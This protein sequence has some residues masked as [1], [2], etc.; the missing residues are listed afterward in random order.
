MK[1]HIS[2]VDLRKLTRLVG[3]LTGRA[4]G[5]EDILT[6]TLEK[7]KPQLVISVH[8]TYYEIIIG[9]ERSELA[10]EFYQ[11]LWKTKL[12]WAV[13][14]T[15]RKMNVKRVWIIYGDCNTLVVFI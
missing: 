4:V 12:E 8:E 11:W 15:A 7:I 6:P 2:E 13:E 10:A 1:T 9:K 3:N 5:V 14:I